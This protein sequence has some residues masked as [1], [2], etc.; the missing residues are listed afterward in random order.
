MHK[1]LCIFS[2]TDS[3]DEGSNVEEP[4]NNSDSD[5]WDELS[6]ELETEEGSEIQDEAMDDAETSS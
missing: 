1:K 4:V 6:E 5:R 3:S 2:I